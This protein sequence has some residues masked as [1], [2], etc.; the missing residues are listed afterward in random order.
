[1]KSNDNIWELFPND[2]IPLPDEHRIKQAI[3]LGQEYIEQNIPAGTPVWRLFYDQIKY[4]SPL[5][6]ATQ[7][8]A[9]IAVISLALS[10]EPNLF[11]AQTALL[12]IAPLT[13]IFVVPEIIKDSLC[14]MTELE[15]SC[16]N[17]GSTI[18]LIRLIAVGFINIAALSLFVSILAGTW[19]YSFLS[20]ILYAFVPYNCVSI[21]CLGLIRLLKVKGRSAALVV[22]LLS[23]ITVFIIPTSVAVAD[24]SASVMLAAFVGTAMIL[25]FQIIGIVRSMSVGGMFNGITD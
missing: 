19:N 11:S 25:T 5:L 9:L 22:A 2:S 18:L 4:L 6:W 13:A 17:N 20:L 15:S 21:I 14:C 23:A 8:L 1:M 3:L 16:K 24:F 10:G 12:Q 7:F